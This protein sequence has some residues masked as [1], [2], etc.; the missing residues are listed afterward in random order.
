MT[1]EKETQALT[2]AGIMPRLV[3]RYLELSEAC[4][5]VS[6]SRHDERGHFRKGHAGR[7]THPALLKKVDLGQT[8]EQ[9]YERFFGQPDEPSSI[10]ISIS[11]N[12]C[13]GSET[14]SSEGERLASVASKAA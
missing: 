7:R 14:R 3:R 13:Q 10:S 11:N 6:V 12:R 5:R 1:I 4:Y 9:V 8:L 2:M